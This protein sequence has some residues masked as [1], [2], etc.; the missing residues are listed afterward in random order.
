MGSLYVAH[1]TPIS[2]GG[3]G[4]RDAILL[5]DLLKLIIPS[6]SETFSMV[7][8]A[9][10]PSTPKRTD[11]LCKTFRSITQHK[12]KLDSHHLESQGSCSYIYID[13]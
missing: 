4:G 10:P 3:L 9:P 6:L 11:R 2:L 1:L 12:W 8:V 7:T 13:M 5:K